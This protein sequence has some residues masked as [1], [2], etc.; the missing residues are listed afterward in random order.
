[1]KTRHEGPGR[2]EAPH[3][4]RPRER[5]P[6][7]LALVALA[8]CGRE[9]VVHGLEEA[10]ANEVVVALDE[11][12]VGAEKRREEGTEERWAV[13]VATASAARAQR[14]L[15]ERELPRPRPDGFREVFGKGSLVPTAVEERA[16]YLHALAGELARSVEAIDGV[17]AARVHL[18]L[19][20]E[21]PLHAGP[22]LLPC[23]AV[24]VKARPGARG[25]VEPLAAGVQALVAGAIAGLAP[26]AVSV[27]V[28]EGPAIAPEPAARSERRPALLLAAGAVALAGGALLVWPHR[29][30]LRA[31][32][33]HRQ[34]AP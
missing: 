31:A 21:D 15:A 27:V 30:M 26:A 14:I 11:R 9:E 4:A 24:L 20:I 12:G 33:R 2:P 13:A 34:V 32:S 5:L 8:G 10:Q 16:L 1:M 17:I 7:L 28:T 23:A 22:A 29:S 6:I 19:P 3:A 18:A 25:R